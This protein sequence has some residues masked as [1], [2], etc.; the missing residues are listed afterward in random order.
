MTTDDII[1]LKSRQKRRLYEPIVLYKALT[2]ITHEQGALRPVEVP[3]RPRTEEE[4]Y[5]NFLHKL[6]SICDS[7]KGGKTV[8][9]I[10]ILDEEEKYKYVFA[11]N[12]ISDR[13]LS[14][15]RDLLTTVLTSLYDFHTFPLDKKNT[16]ESEILKKIL[17]FNSPRINCYLNALKA[18]NI[19]ECLEYC[20]MQTDTADTSIEEGLRSLDRAIEDTTFKNMGN[21][22]YFE[23][24]ST[25]QH[26]LETFLTR[27]VKSYIDKRATNGRFSEGRSFACWSELRHSL[28]RLQ[29]YKKTV[30]DL[31]AAEG[32][33]PD[34]FQ[35]LEVVSVKSS[36]TEPNPLGKKSE[37]ASNILGRMCSN[38][39]SR[40]R[41]CD[42]AQNL[43]M[44]DLDDRIQTQCAKSTFKPYVHC[45]ILVLEW[46]MTL[47]R[48][49][50]Q[51]HHPG[52]TFFNDWSYIGSSKPACQLCRYYFDTAGQHNG[53][54]TRA[55]HGNLYVNWRFPDLHESDGTFGQTRRQSIFNSMIEKIRQ[56]AFGILVTRNSGGK[57]HD[58][59]THPLMSVRYTDVQTE[60]SVRDLPDVDELGEDFAVG[61]SLDSPS[62]SL[63]ESDFDDEDGGTSLG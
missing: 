55:G 37:K 22:E 28:S 20:Q 50:A 24:Y 5:H 62:N 1:S 51:K 8:T 42:L 9:S 10:A 41:Y 54:R 27:E 30:Q 18:K 3:E 52:V 49:M 58:S 26:A 4:R 2:E 44:F 61:L 32:E 35:E 39:A 36:Q 53:I 6:A 29:S 21:N 45:E 17:S 48:E 43:Q 14:D 47:N 38:E 15:T 40:Q 12:Q 63:E 60:L 31:I 23:T 33:W 25:I 57:R 46:I 34:I 56:D 11:C 7:T 19:V 13:D 59:S 16:V